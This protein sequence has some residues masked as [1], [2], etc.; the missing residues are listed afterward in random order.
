MDCNSY[1]ILIRQTD[2]KTVFYCGKKFLFL[3]IMCVMQP[4]EAINWRDL[5]LYRSTCTI[6]KNTTGIE[7]ML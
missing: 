5:W 2:Q 1:L 3:K 4:K 6:D 7:Q